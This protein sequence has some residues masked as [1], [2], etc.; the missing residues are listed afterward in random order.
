MRIPAWQWVVT[1][2]VIVLPLVFGG[3][4]VYRWFRPGNRKRPSGLLTAVVAFL[5]AWVLVVLLVLAWAVLRA[6][7]RPTNQQSSSA[8]SLLAPN[9]ALQRTRF[10]APLSFEPFGAAVKIRAG[11]RHVAESGAAQHRPCVHLPIPASTAGPM[12]SPHALAP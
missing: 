3:R 8:V 5:V 9:K 6:S 11:G 2:V 10:R 7:L 4:V 1:V 12:G